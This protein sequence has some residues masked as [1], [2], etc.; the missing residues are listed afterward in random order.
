MRT[1][2]LAITS[3]FL[4]SGCR[5]ATPAT[6]VPNA[7]SALASPGSCHGTEGETRPLLV[8]WPAADRAQL[9][10][11]AGQGLV[12]VRYDGCQMQILSRCELEGGYD[13][14]ALTQKRDELR[15]RDRDALWA[16]IPLG[17]AR[18]EAALSRDGQLNVDM[19]VVG[20]REANVAQARAVGNGAACGGATHVVTA[21]TVGAFSLYTGRAI[22]GDVQA[23]AQ[24]AG[25]GG[26]LA[27]ST[28][29][30]RSDGDLARC[31]AA[32]PADT[33]PPAQCGALLRVELAP[34]GAGG[35]LISDAD[36]RDATEAQA[37]REASQRWQGVR[38][39]SRIGTG[40]TAA[41]ALGAVVFVVVRSAQIASAEFDRDL[42]ARTADEDD[43][44]FAN[45][46]ERQ[47]AAQRV[48]ELDSD[49][50]R[51]KSSRRTA[52]FVGVGLAVGAGALLG[53]A[54]GARN[55]SHTLER[56]ADTLSVAPFGGPGVGGVSIEGR[57]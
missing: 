49:I 46:A 8:E 4:A 43:P 33:Q 28:E 36:A 35:A 50:D 5:G 17:A 54:A 9:E 27:R 1:C 20:Q 40:L 11:A 52:G 23:S 3:L 57:F 22:Q 30:L 47:R 10:A 16:K 32:M 24:G 37:L 25:G 51:Y 56:R 26:Q 12:A 34:L 7:S 42:E 31:S 38:R 13:Y 6:S 19:M 45:D 2:A 14:H 29:T 53:L 15:I 44:F 41:G 21:M 39:G 48:A 55:R 18:L